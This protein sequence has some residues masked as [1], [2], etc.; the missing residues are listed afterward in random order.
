MSDA[1]SISPLASIGAPG[2]DIRKPD[3]LNHGVHIGERTRVREFVTI[4]GGFEQ[5][6]HIGSD[7]LVSAHSHV[8]H[9]CFV[10]DR[11]MLARATLGGHTIVHEGAFVGLGAITHQRI[12]IGAYA[13]VGAGSVV[14]RDVLPF[15]LVYGNPAKQHGYNVVG[16]RRAGFSEEQIGYIESGGRTAYQEAFERDAGRHK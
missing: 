9:D 15:A 13:M 5:Q 12:T 1:P 10:G 3:P 11:V 7:C 16:M 14:T 6:T 2:E 8:G 4:H